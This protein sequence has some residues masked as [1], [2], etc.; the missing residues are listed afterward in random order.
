MNIA[1]KQAN[2]LPPVFFC[3]ICRRPGDI[4]PQMMS[5]LRRSPV[6]AAFVILFVALW[7]SASAQTVTLLTP[8]DI[9]KGQEQAVSHTVCESGK[10]Y[11]MPASFAVIETKYATG[12]HIEIAEPSPNA[13]YRA[14]R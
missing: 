6:T 2:C 10:C 5:S 9:A 4:I 13:E 3:L 12:P 8:E 7:G 14:P 1:Q 11:E